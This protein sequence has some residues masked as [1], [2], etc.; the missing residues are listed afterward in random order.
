M[1]IEN[2]QNPEQNKETVFQSWLAE[3]QGRF[4]LNPDVMPEGVYEAIQTY[5]HFDAHR[6]GR[7]DE[8]TKKM[9]EATANFEKLTSYN[10]QDFIKYQDEQNHK[11]KVDKK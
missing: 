10:I 3:F 5:E 9:N 2:P 11:L 6:Q 8:A 1:S 4:W 7:E